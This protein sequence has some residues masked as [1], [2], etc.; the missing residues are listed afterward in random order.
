MYK[1]RKTGICF[2]SNKG[3][4]LTSRLQRPHFKNL[5]GT[6]KTEV[7]HIA[8]KTIILNLKIIRKNVGKY[9]CIN[10]KTYRKFVKVGF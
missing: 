6:K 10:I 9:A 1:S 4:L 7:F 3:I 2:P 5:C 8:L